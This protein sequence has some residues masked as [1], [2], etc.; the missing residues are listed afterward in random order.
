[1][2]LNLDIE[3]Q[4]LLTKMS[5]LPFHSQ[6]KPPDTLAALELAKKKGAMI[7][8]IVNVVGSSIARMTDS[9][10]Y[11]HAGSRNWSGFN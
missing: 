7:Y 1:M 6:A 11:I 8:G 10:S 4:S 9:G 2:L 5:S 3:I